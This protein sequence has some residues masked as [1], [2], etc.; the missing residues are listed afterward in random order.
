M[1]GLL[2]ALV[3]GCASP[4]FAASAGTAGAQFL[5]LGAGARFGAMAD[6][7]VA[8]E[9]D[10]FSQYY[11]PAAL[12]RLERPQLGGAHS[13]MF[14]GVTY[15][16]LVYA[17]PWGRRSGREGLQTAGN[18]HAL[19]FGV[20][21]LGVGD[22]ERRTGDSTTAIGT[23]N[24]ADAAYAL[25]YSHAPTDRLSLG[26]TGKYVSQTLDSYSGNAFAADLG[27]QYRLNPH[28]EKPIVV[29]A[30]VKHLGSK[31]G[32]VSSAR[33]PLPTTAL[34]GASFAPAKAFTLALDAGKGS[35]TDAHVS[36][37][38]EGRK[39]LGESAA[40]SFR[41]GYTSIRREQGGLNGIAAGVGLSFPR[42][43]FDFAW[44][45]FGTLGDAIRFSLL[46]KF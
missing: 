15:Q 28:A 19:A 41:F 5:K 27:V 31:I 46:I 9:G 36:F 18:R 21:Y 14:Q 16:T 30:A 35:D 45:P 6:T 12:S 26:F 8:V 43:A 38:A 34:V 17:Y 13:A 25:S 7:G 10:A 20:Y 22:I 44:I 4:A 23:F 24:S 29:G 39:T 37:G 40:G 33:D 42:A 11:N 2:A 32:Y 3:L 1:N